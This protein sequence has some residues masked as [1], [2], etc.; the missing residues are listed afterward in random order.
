[1]LIKWSYAPTLMEGLYRSGGKNEQRQGKNF[2]LIQIDTFYNA[3]T[4]NWFDCK[5]PFNKI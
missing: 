4:T 3:S 1:M 5:Q 2:D